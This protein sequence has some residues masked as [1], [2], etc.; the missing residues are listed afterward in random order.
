MK[1]KMIYIDLERFLL[2]VRLARVRWLET[3]H[4]LKPKAED[5]AGEGKGVANAR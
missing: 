5:S 2:T 4:H 3:G 1:A